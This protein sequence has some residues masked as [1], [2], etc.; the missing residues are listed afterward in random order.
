MRLSIRIKAKNQLPWAGPSRNDKGLVILVVNLLYTMLTDVPYTPTSDGV[1]SG[2]GL[3]ASGATTP[4]A[5]KSA[6]SSLFHPMLQP[7]LFSVHGSNV[8]RRSRPVICPQKHSFDLQG[9]R[10]H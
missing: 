7:P 2:H 8:A 9:H 5:L 4:Y 10:N 1:A 3:L 6:L